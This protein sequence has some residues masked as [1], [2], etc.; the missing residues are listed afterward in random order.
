VA[1][2]NLRDL[3]RRYRETLDPR[4]H[5]RLLRARIRSG[6][7]LQDALKLG[8]WLGSPGAQL[9]HFGEVC[10]DPRPVIG[11]LDARQRQLEQAVADQEFEL[12]VEHRGAR[13]RLLSF[14]DCPAP[15]PWPA[16]DWV[17]ELAAAFPVA[18]Q[19][20]GLALGRW[21]A[22]G[23]AGRERKGLAKLER[24]AQERGGFVALEGDLAE[25]LAAL[26]ALIRALPAL[27]PS[28]EVY[29]FVADELVPWALGAASP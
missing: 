15:L 17:E 7:L 6:S 9:A 1:D 19:R 22:E 25:E 13:E 4:D 21:W 8:A 5:A 28:Q 18:A 10:P 14:W 11:E 3:E 20:I 12:A 2:S 26:S 27:E 23:D 16:R 24:R 29:Q